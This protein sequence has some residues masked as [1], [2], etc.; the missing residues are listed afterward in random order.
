MNYRDYAMMEFK[1][2]GWV[3]EE[4]NWKDGMQEAMCSSVL[5]LLDV[6][7]KEGHSGTSAPYAVNLFKDLALFKPIIPLTGEDWEWKPCSDG[8]MQNKRCSHVF[9]GKDGKAYD[10]EGRIFWEWYRGEDDIPRKTHFM[11]AG[12]S[13]EVVFPYMPT[14]EY[15]FR[16]T[17][18]FPN[19]EI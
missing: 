2:A 9:K 12:S 1:A 8:E 19:E 13:T 15:V 5:D 18:E 11:G 7:S 16:P 17:E 3:D 14:R 6:F 4:G 10:I